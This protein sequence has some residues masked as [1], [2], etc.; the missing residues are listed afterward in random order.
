[1]AEDIAD[2]EAPVVP[3]VKTTGLQS[4]SPKQPDILA[5]DTYLTPEKKYPTENDRKLALEQ[6]R[7][8]NPIEETKQYVEKNMPWTKRVLERNRA[9]VAQKAQVPPS[10]PTEVPKEGLL[11][12]LKKFIVGK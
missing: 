10:P 3:V 1:M 8:I 5:K 7:T 2:T 4:P 11:Q 6:A 12:R 9:E